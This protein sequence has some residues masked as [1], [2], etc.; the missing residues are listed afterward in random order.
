MKRI[1]ALILV[2]LTLTLLISSAR[3]FEIKVLNTPYINI[4]GKELKVGNKFDEK[5]FINW[6][7]ERQAMK[8]L[9][10]DNKVYVL[11]K[12]L[13]AKHKAKSFA[14]YLTSVKSASARNDGENFPVTVADH[15]AIFEGDFALLD[16]ISFN[17]GWRIDELSYFEARTNNLDKNV[18]FIIPTIEGRLV[19]TKYFLKS[20]S[21]DYDKIS[22]TII[23]REKEYND[24]TLVTESMNIEIVPSVIIQK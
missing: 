23:Y 7:N 2:F 10:E 9:S 5:A 18:S 16:S 15:Q 20:L 22:F 8:V 14:D 21:L 13:L 11:S 17:V 19:L 12:G 4:G 3:T 1:S 24:T 6:S